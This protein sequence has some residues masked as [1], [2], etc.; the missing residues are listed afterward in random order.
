MLYNK[1]HWGA[2]RGQNFYRGP[3][4]PLAPLWTA[5]ERNLARRSINNNATSN[6]NNV[7]H[8]FIIST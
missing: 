8:L 2:T 7:Q 6:N 1:L 4:L 3:R 5:P